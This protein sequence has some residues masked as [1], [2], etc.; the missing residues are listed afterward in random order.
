MQSVWFKQASRSRFRMNLKIHLGIWLSQAGSRFVTERS[1]PPLPSADSSERNA[2]LH[3]GTRLFAPIWAGDRSCSTLR[4][5]GLKRSFYGLMIDSFPGCE[6]R[7]H[8]CC[9]RS[10]TI[11]VVNRL[12][13]IYLCI[14]GFMCRVV[15][16]Y[17]AKYTL[18]LWR[19]H[20]GLLLFLKVLFYYYCTC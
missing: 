20:A 12:W 14:Y 19:S 17:S 9:V 16:L 18:V 7:I 10:L 3:V 2:V 11:R 8:V 5:W 6:E 4:Q 15:Q 13:W 1:F